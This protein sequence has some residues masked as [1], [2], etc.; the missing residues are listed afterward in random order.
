MEMAVILLI[1][2][3]LKVKTTKVRLLTVIFFYSAHPNFPK[4]VYLTLLIR[5]TSSILIEHKYSNFDPSSMKPFWVR[6]TLS[7]RIST[8]VKLISNVCQRSHNVWPAYTGRMNHTPAYVEKF[9][10]S[11]KFSTSSPYCDVYQ[12][13]S[14][15]L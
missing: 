15:C 8:Y 10:A 5:N 3:I 7:R 14:A 4:T 1:F 2:V 13:A 12:R 6:Y 9:C 11:T